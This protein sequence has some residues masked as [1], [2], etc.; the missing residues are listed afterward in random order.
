MQ[1]II[2][3][4]FPLHHQGASLLKFSHIVPVWDELSSKHALC[5]VDDNLLV[6]CAPQG[7]G[8]EIQPISGVGVKSVVKLSLH[9]IDC[10]GYCEIY[11]DVNIGLLRDGMS[12]SKTVAFNIYA[13]AGIVSNR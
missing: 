5:I 6:S 4:D 10:A 13:R 8:R 3:I 9:G 1:I 12:V 2:N 11:G 7:K